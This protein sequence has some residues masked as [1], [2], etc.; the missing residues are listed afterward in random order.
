MSN[1]FEPMIEMYIFETVQL[2]EQI[3]QCILANE[4][5][6]KLSEIDI[7][8]IFRHMHTI[9]GSSGMMMYDNIAHLAHTIEDIFFVLREES[10]INYNFSDLADLIFEGIDF[11]KIEVEKIKNGDNPDGDI[12]HLISK[13]KEYL[14]LIE[15]KNQKEVKEINENVKYYISQDKSCVE[16]KYK[17]SFRAKI[18]FE[19]GCEMENIRAYT[20]IHNLKEITNDIFHIPEEVINNEDSAEEIKKNG[21][22]IYLKTNQSYKEAYDFFSETIFLKA[23]ELEEMI[24][25]E[26]EISFGKKEDKL[27]TRS[28]LTTDKKDKKIS[29]SN[30]INVNVDKLDKLMDIVGEMVIAESMVIQN[31]DLTGLKLNN[32]NKA[33]RLL[34]KLTSELQDLVMSIRM[35]PLANTFHKMNRIVRDMNKKLGKNV[36]LEIRGE[37]TEV[38][39]NIIEHISDPIMH[40]VR[41]SLDHGI[42]TS[43]ERIKSN[44][45]GKGKILLEAK[46]S[47]NDV[48]IIV[49]DDGRGLDKNKLI[50]KAKENNLLTKEPKDYTDKEIYSLIFLPGFSTKKDV[51]EFSGRGVGMDVVTKNIETIGGNITIES[52]KGEGT[53]FI[54][55]I[56][57]TLAIIEGMNIKVGSSRYTIPI[58]DIRESF[59]AEDKDIIK[60][61]DNSE[62]ILVRGKCYPIIRLSKIYNV[63]T[64]V[65]KFSKGVLIMIEND[66]QSICIL[67]DEL[68]GQQQVVVKNLPKYIQ[69]TKNIEGI[70]GCTLLG[71]GSISLILDPSKLIHMYSK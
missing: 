5:A 42:E 54:I 28:N 56:P 71:D 64:N 20:I 17:N 69:Q 11:I 29:S 61:P 59:R 7:N 36:E 8:E 12:T 58:C 13:L 34:N 2:I 40:L 38:D 1:N 55:K 19:E 22:I 35:V 14:L 9:K 57:L 47:G 4:G 53:S 25:E 21:F 52:K 32:F 23:L 50:A 41:N 10:H 43:E 24:E 60:N 68:V 33:S 67:V 46:N 15:G 3:E 18:F 37:E 6:E 66:I 65:D 48:M 62:M 63:K 49:R 30:M 45:N 51:T 27:I 16:E 31:P 39:K 26:W 70:T 44:K